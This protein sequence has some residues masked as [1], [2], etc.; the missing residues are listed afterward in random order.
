[1]KLW[2]NVLLP[3]VKS[4]CLPTSGSVTSIVYQTVS[5]VSNDPLFHVVG[6]FN[7]YVYIT[8]DYNYFNH[9][10]TLYLIILLERVCLIGYKVIC[11]VLYEVVNTFI[12]P[13]TSILKSDFLI[14]FIALMEYW[15][16]SNVLD[17]IRFTM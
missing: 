5:L 13:G 10:I 17:L 15:Y 14:G 9:C 3:Q 1:M 8:N 4:C 2:T 12:L 11:I 16:K 6:C 7:M